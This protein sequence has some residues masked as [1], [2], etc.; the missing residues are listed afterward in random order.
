MILIMFRCIFIFIIF[1]FIIFLNAILTLNVLFIT[2]QINIFLN[3][4]SYLPFFFL[5]FKI[6]N[7][8]NDITKWYIFN[9]TPLH[10]AI[11]NNNNE[12]V[13]LL[14]ENPKLD[15]NQES[16]FLSIFECNSKNN[17]FKYHSQNQIVNFVLNIHFFLLCLRYN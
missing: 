9:R 16:I 1:E 7:H 14:L 13:K 5:M 17:N 12:I 8:L 4:I 6:L 2:F 10:I 15:V 11:E 3:D